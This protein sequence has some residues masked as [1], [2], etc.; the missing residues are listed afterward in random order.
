MKT[1]INDLGLQ[2]NVEF[3]GLV[4]QE[5]LV[6]LY[7]KMDV[8]VFPTKREAES[9]GLVGLE[10]MSCKTPVIG[11][12]IAGLKTY[13]ENYRNGMLFQPGN[14]F[15]LSTCIEKY[16][17]FSIQEK[18][19]MRNAAFNSAKQYESGYVIE[20]LLEQLKKVCTRN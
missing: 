4:K 8:M 12:D 2:N 15:E 3:L 13:I 10:A 20:K 7:N 16:L 1:M 17:N 11:G 18:E 5:E 19:D 14:V 9:L 6:H